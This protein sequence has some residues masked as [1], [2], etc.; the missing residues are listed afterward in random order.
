MGG[1]HGVKP[2]TPKISGEVK[3]NCRAKARTIF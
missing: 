2:V 1:W 3:Q